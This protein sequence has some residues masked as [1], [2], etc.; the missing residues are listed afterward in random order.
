MGWGHN[1]PD[2]N[3]RGGQAAARSL[4][5]FHQISVIISWSVIDPGQ[6]SGPS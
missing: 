4:A 2:F 1:F 6:G 5:V 3:Q